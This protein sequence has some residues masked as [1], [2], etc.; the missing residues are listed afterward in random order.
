MTPLDL[1]PPAGSS[2]AL[3][4]EFVLSASSLLVLLVVAWRHTTD[5]DARLAGWLSF[6]GLLAAG[7]APHWLWLAGASPAG[8]PQMVSTRSA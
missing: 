7:A 2:V 8:L 6:V 5:A 1:T 3:L 4:P